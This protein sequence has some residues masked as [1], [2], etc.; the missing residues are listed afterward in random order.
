MAT[1]LPLEA[2]HT[3]SLEPG[4]DE[5]LYLQLYSEIRDAVLHRRFPPGAKLPSSRAFAEALGISRN[6]VV[7]A[8]D[9][10]TDEGFLVR[11]TGSGSYVADTLPDRFLRAEGAR[12]QRGTRPPNIGLSGRGRRIA[13]LS[14]R[15]PPAGIRPFA[16]GLPDF[17]ALPLDQWSR[18]VGKHWRNVRPGMLSY[19]NVGGLPEL[20]RAITAYLRACRAVTCEPEQV[21]ITSG[22]QQA[23]D[24][25]TRLLLD[26]GD[27]AWLEEPGYPGA[28]GAL[29]AAG[30]R[31]VPVPVDRDGVDPERGSGEPRLIYVTPSHQYPMG[32]TLSLPRR[33][34]LLE[35]TRRHDCWLVEDDYDSE[36]RFDTRP[37]ASL[38][39]LD[40]QGRVLYVGT[41]SK[42]LF[43]SLRLGYVVVP[44]DLVDAFLAA[45]SFQDAQPPVVVQ[46]AL[47][48]LI[49]SGRFVSHIRRMRKCYAARYEIM[50]DLIHRLLSEW[51]EIDPTPAGMHLT[52]RGRQKA[53]DDLA[54][55]E[56]G[57]TEG[58]VLRPLTHYYAAEPEH[59]G[60]VMGYAGFSED[61]LASAAEKLAR[62]LE[63]TVR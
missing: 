55:S 3:I 15:A 43:P 38:Q 32:V 51:L 61:A 31:I 16:P 10:L 42:V 29:I 24:L 6:T 56:V 23:M 13:R 50:V 34:R 27:T 19:G 52:A 60:F 2:I 57:R 47:A 39:G 63:R 7:T 49:D 11:R 35:L 1:K 14:R 58:L 4:S 22:A 5:P 12:E 17:S 45:R 18:L 28:R 20:Q 40:D 62:L 26:E 46:A 36:Y 48:E 30:A 9:Q 33:L 25:I 59:A 41:F 53:F 54:I 44:E 8:Y 21:I 37:L